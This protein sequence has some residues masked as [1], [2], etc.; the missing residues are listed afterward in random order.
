MLERRSPACAGTATAKIGHDAYSRCT[1]P[2]KESPTDPTGLI[3]GESHQR[4]A[5][6]LSKPFAGAESV[7]LSSAG[8]P[9]PRE[10]SHLVFKS[11]AAIARGACQSILGQV[12]ERQT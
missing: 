7:S 8:P 9:S 3:G 10:K 6:A 5:D 11:D 2:S 4:Q 1:A 12:L